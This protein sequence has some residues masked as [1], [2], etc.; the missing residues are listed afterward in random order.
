[1][2]PLHKP[3]HIAAVLILVAVILALLVA[4]IW[5][6]V[7]RRWR[8]GALCLAAG[9]GPLALI[10][11]LTVEAVAAYVRGD[12]KAARA[13][14]TAAIV[15]TVATAVALLLMV[16]AANPDVAWWQAPAFWLGL[17]GLWVPMAIGVFYAAVFAHLGIRRVTTLNATAVWASVYSITW[18]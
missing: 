6:L 8:Y 12:G 2:K 14:L 3:R 9:V 17:L 18:R 7:R 1:M 11:L 10:P 16:G 13:P 15:L 5:Q 4:G